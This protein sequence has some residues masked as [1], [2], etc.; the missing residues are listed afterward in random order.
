MNFP[1]QDSM[2]GMNSSSAL[3]SMFQNAHMGKA[4]LYDNQGGKMKKKQPMLHSDP[5]ILGY[6]FHNAECVGLN[7]MEM[8]DY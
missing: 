8:D 6:S 1:L 5:S 4:G 2:R 7:E 3:Q